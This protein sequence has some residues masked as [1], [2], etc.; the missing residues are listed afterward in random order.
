MTFPK[1]HRLTDMRVVATMPPDE[2]IVAMVL[3]KDRPLLAT[4]KGVYWWEE[5]SQRF[6]PVEIAMRDSAEPKATDHP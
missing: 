4:S 6:L 5:A 3:F 2:P 1:D